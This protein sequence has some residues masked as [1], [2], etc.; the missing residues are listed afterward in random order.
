MLSYVSLGGIFKEYMYFG[1]L[2]R[3]QQ[4]SNYIFTMDFLAGRHD[5]VFK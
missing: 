2:S 1:H 4:N 3:L 5:Y